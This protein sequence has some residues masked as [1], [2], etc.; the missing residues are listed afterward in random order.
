M[1]DPTTKPEIYRALKQLI[2]VIIGRDYAK[3][4]TGFATNPCERIKECHK[5]CITDQAASFGNH[6]KSAQIQRKIDSLN[7]LYAL[8]RL[9]EAVK[10]D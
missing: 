9:A 6:E 8:A 1:N 10:W 4:T 2:N 5:L 3:A 7:S